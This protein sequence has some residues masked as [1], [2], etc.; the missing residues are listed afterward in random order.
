M[1]SL[2]KTSTEYLTLLGEKITTQANAAI[3]ALDIE[4]NKEVE[5]RQDEYVT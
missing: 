4:F 1:K 3:Q 2:D 5:R